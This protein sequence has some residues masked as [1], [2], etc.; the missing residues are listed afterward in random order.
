MKKVL[1]LIIALMLSFTVTA[2]FAAEKKNAKKATVTGE[3]IAIDAKANT[4][5]VK[6]PKKGEIALT[7]ND[8]TKIMDGK[9]KKT[10]SD[11]KAGDKVAVEY[12]EAGDNNTAN[13]IIIKAAS[14]K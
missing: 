2:A 14:A 3:V 12:D 8:K 10:L 9:D 4:L 6:G 7:A 13:K 1:A 5:T 11:V